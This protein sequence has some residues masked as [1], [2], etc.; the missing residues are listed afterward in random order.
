MKEAPV[1]DEAMIDA[2]RQAGLLAPD[3][4]ARFTALTG[5][6]SSDIWKVETTRSVF[7]VK[8]ALAK[9]KVAADWFAPVER[10]RFELAWIKTAN[11]IVPGVAPR[12]LADDSEAML[13][14][15]DYLDPAQHRLWKD[16]LHRGNAN[17]SDGQA[18]GERLARIHSAT[19]N[20]P[21]IAALFPA[22]DIFN[23]IRLE[24]YLEATATHHRDL[25]DQLF[26]LSARTK[27]IKISMIHGDV[28]PKNILLGPDGP[29]FIDAECACIGDPA[30]DLAFCLNHFL[31][32]CLWTPAAS[33]DFLACFE[34]MGKA[35]LAGVDWEEPA[36][37]EA[38]AASLLPGL[39][40]ARVDGKSPVEYITR[41][42]DKDKVRKCARDL[43]INPPAHLHDISTRWA[44]VR[45][46]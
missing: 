43:V 20:A 14:A 44:R 40:L 18:C 35:Y 42:E 22:N 31:L 38:R 29:V 32:K 26:G 4:Y 19:A 1:P 16:E 28:S 39:F 33:A 7:C 8:R 46:H 3:R 37:L 17:P 10:N 30:F 23:A 34:A 13:F 12:I 24:P 15:M 5:G 25:R 21:E 6:V 27:N 11:T 45:T 36:T 2:L 41:E 9:L